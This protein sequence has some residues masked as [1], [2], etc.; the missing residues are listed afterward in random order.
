MKSSGKEE[1]AGFRYDIPSPFADFIGSFPLRQEDGEQGPQLRTFRLQCRISPAW[2]AV[3]G[4]GRCRS[5][6]LVACDIRA[7]AMLDA[8]RLTHVTTRHR[9]NLSINPLVGNR[10]N[11]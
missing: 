8:R 10:A 9:V 2:L 3:R 5:L 6:N 7:G 1:G 4:C 11:L